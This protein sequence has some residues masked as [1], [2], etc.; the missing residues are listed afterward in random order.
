M[1]TKPLLRSVSRSS[2]EPDNR[3]SLDL[4]VAYIRREHSDAEA[5]WVS[6][7][8]HAIKIGGWLREAKGQVKALKLGNWEDWC[9]AQGFP[10]KD[11]TRRNYMKLSLTCELHPERVE[12]FEKIGY[13]GAM[14]RLS[15]PRPKPQFIADPQTEVPTRQVQETS[16]SGG[17]I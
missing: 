14:R 12:E 15:V 3:V 11:S 7:L 13:T 6:W 17:R 5:A 16:G 9:R 10:F 8:R 1:Y 2:A 4:L